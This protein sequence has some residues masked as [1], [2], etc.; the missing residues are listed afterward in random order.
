M[1]DWRRNGTERTAPEDIGKV[2]DQTYSEGDTISLRSGDAWNEQVTLRGS[3]TAEAPITLTSYG[4]GNRP[5]LYRDNGVDDEVIR[6]DNG[7]GYVVQ[8]LRSR[9]PEGGFE[10]LRTAIRSRGSSITGSRTIIFIIFRIYMAV[11]PAMRAL[12]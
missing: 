5:Y 11:R 9:M 12:R 10:S 2:S 7:D 3:G 1:M 8:G 6:I 4:A